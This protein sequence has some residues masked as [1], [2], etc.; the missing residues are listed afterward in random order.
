MLIK[1]SNMSWCTALL[2]TGE[3]LWFKKTS[4]WYF[5]LCMGEFTEIWRRW[6]CLN[7]SLYRCRAKVC[8][9]GKPCD[10]EQTATAVS[11]CKIDCTWE[12]AN[13]RERK[14]EGIEMNECHSQATWPRWWETSM[15]TCAGQRKPLI[16]PASKHNHISDSNA[17]QADFNHKQ[18]LP[19]SV[20]LMHKLCPQCL[21][22]VWPSSVNYYLVKC[23]RN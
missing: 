17:F 9:D 13:E 6:C 16:K 1:G 15:W 11:Y 21:A 18:R 4:T 12:W 5:V 2:V 19:V 22:C 14:R 10:S 23:C 7:G 8:S 3:I 20:Q